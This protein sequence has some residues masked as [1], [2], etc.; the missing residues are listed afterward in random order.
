MR[1]KTG[2]YKQFDADDRLEFP[3]EGYAGWCKDDLEL[4]LSRTAI[5]V[6][7][8]WDSGS[9]DRFPGWYRAVEFLPRANA[10]AEQEL[11]RLL[12]ASREAGM[13]VFH[14][15]EP[16]G[17]YYKQYPGYKHAVELAGEEDPKIEQIPVDES[18]ANLEAFRKAN[19]FPGAH[20]I[21]DINAG[22]ARLAI[23]DSVKPLGNEG[24]VATSGQLFALCQEQGINHL[25]YTGFALNAC[26]LLNPGGMHD[27]KRHGL[28]CSVV[29]EAVT[30]VENKE[31]A[32]GE[33]AK[34]LSLWSVSLFFG[35]VYSLEDLVSALSESKLG[36]G[37]SND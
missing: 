9:R 37:H 5:V 8:A 12:S 30:A 3:G 22:F 31:T 16:I 17:D 21:D 28:L 24:V 25:I 20:N 18:H 15:V 27:M 35:F 34:R 2:Y 1:V 11:P 7:H 32:R 33:E 23:P 4:D 6:M 26:L 29:P 36:A 13:T 19:A 14:V 10:I